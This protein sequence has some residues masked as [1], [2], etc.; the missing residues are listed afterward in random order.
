MRP[1]QDMKLR[2]ITFALYIA[3]LSRGPGFF[4]LGLM[5][6]TKSPFHP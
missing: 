6:P 2:L 3:N 4:G 1:T 5:T